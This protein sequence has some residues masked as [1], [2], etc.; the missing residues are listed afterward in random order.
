MLLSSERSVL[1]VVDVQER[2]MPAVADGERVV[3]NVAVL[4]KAAAALSV[5]VLLTE[6]YP[7]GLGPTVAAVREAV[8][9]DSVFEKITFS[10]AGAPAFMDR[11][12]ALKRPQVVLAGAEAH[13]CVLQTA[14]ALT[15]A[16]YAVFLVADATASRVPA[17][18]EL[19]VAR[20]RAAGVTIV[21]T[22]MVVF[23]WLERAGTPTFKSL[24]GVIK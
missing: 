16:G 3:G 9:P 5:P 11:L 1:I 21:S 18:V 14:L 20:M 22:E 2:L 8:P 6:Q 23:E 4:Q 17:N 10:S 13:V 24:I 7:K 12:G 19:A 15:A